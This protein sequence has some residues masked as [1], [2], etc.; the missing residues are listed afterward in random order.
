M[1]RVSDILITNTQHP[2]ILTLCQFA[3]NSL[4]S[5]F[6]RC[7][8]QRSTYAW[9]YGI[10]DFCA[11][12]LFL[13]SIAWLWHY[14]GAEIQHFKELANFASIS[15]YSVFVKNMPRDWCIESFDNKK[16][17]EESTVL[18][19]KIAKFFT[20]QIKEHVKQEY[21]DDV[22]EFGLG[23]TLQDN[24]I[25]DST[26]KIVA[27]VTLCLDEGEDIKFYQSRKPLTRD[28]NRTDWHIKKLNFELKEEKETSQEDG[29]NPKIIAKLQKQL[30]YEKKHR[31]KVVE[32]MN[33]V[34]QKRNKSKEKKKQ[35]KKVVGAFVTFTTDMAQHLCVERYPKSYCSW[36]CQKK[37]RRWHGTNKNDGMEYNEE[38]M[39]RVRL[40][41][42]PEPTTLMWENF[43]I[44]FS[45]RMCRK[46]STSLIAL[47]L[48][49]GSAV[50]VY[51]AKTVD[52][53]VADNYCADSKQEIFPGI[54][55]Q[56]YVKNTSLLDTETRC[57]PVLAK[58]P[59]YNVFNAQ[60]EGKNVTGL[61][62]TCYCRKY[63][64][65]STVGPKVASSCTNYVIYSAQNWEL[66]CY[67]VS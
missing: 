25:V 42:A 39:T 11:S 60:Y 7:F 46:L 57:L 54:L 3:N 19:K 18:E 56:D 48:I 33:K 14:E 6:Y 43:E 15:D 4:P 47:C 30:D 34:M 1:E 35:N 40:K 36:L 23:K 52:A 55:C 61:G 26:G 58:Y 32:K 16:I 5:F 62:E 12:I 8:L 64:V 37:D 10:S 13:L 9:F 45:S 51:Y 38:L 28:I 41:K 66:F 31:K 53:T 20:G 50:A 24:M 59:D 22:K 67:Q 63:A 21:A 2:F 29:P 49:I 65:D 17:S 44:G 27:E